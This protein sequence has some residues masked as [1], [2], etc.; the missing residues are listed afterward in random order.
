MSS[1]IVIV[2]SP[3]KAKTIEKFLGKDYT[4]KSSFG[5]VRDLAKKDFGVDIKNNYKPDYEI[6]SDKK[7]IIADLKKS[8]STAQTV[9]LASDEDREGEAI[10][11]HLYEVLNLKK[12]DT[13][14][15]V[16]NEITKSAILNAI[17]N[18][19]TINID[20]VDAQQARRVLDRLV[21]FELSSVLWKK[22]KSQLSAG[23]VQSVS[24]R[25]LV[26]R[27]R[28]I[29]KFVSESAF[30]I[31][32]LFI[33]DNKGVQEILY[34]ELSE[35]FKTKEEVLK[36]MNDCKNANYKVSSVNKKPVK[37]TPAPPF[38]TS[39]LQ[40]EAGRKF[41]FSVSKT[42]QVAQNLYESGFI[43]YMRTDSVNLSNAAKESI[44]DLVVSQYGEKY[45]KLRNF[46][47]K[48]KGAQEAHEAI[49]PSYVE[50]E[51]I[52]G[53]SEQKKLYSLIR[54]RAIASQMSDALLEKT[55]VNIDI[56]TRKEQFIAQGEIV[57]FEGFLKVYQALPDEQSEN[58][59]EKIIPPLK[60]G[61]I[62][63]SD[64]IE[65]IQKFTKHPPRY[66]ESALV[67]KMEELGIGRPSTYAPTISTIQ[68][69]GYVVK[70]NRNGEKRTY[71]YVSLINGEINSQ[72][73]TENYGVEKSKLF[74]TDIGI[75]VNDFLV[76]K[77]PSIVD[78]NFTADVEQQFDQIAAGK[79]VWHKMIDDFYK[80][81]HKIVENTVE[82]AERNSGERILGKDPETGKD[83]SVR[84]GRF[85][86][87][88]QA[89]NTEDAEK[90]R[91]VSIPKDKHLET[92]SLEE[93]LELLKGSG[94]GRK[95]GVDSRTGRNIY[96]RI[97]RFGP[98]VQLGENDDTEKPVFSS[99]KAGMTIENITILQAEE[100]FKLPR[101]VGEYQ[102]KNI[103]AANGKF[104]PYLSFNSS[105][106][107]LKKTDD[108][109]S[110]SLERAIE[111]IEEK[112][113]KD[114][115]KLIKEFPE[116]PSIK[117]INDRWNR[118]CIFYDKKYV[119]ISKIENPKELTLE[120]CKEL[121]GFT[122]KKKTSPS[123]QT[124]AKKA[125]TAKKTSTTKKK[126]E[127]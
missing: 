81:F 7:K 92:I 66:S 96:A 57:V 16:F 106:V 24:V 31:N 118:P 33:V 63:V 49:R 109:L 114:Q 54:N 36:F 46:V 102:G 126:T 105:F 124:T 52:T 27:E 29:I 112:K 87:I 107:S 41:G 59:D 2:E 70:E 104:G 45:H 12:K 61:D 75:V 69:R 76:D 14:R 68:K 19:G 39:T 44:K 79:M 13:K 3:A 103:V 48:S 77:F 37:R 88:V 43:T 98:M 100:L 67:R 42:M 111:L 23:R 22:V 11:W 25:L 26:D 99:L 90:P 78:Y 89:G 94:N 18:P 47:T 71:E 80:P 10:A 51:D 56:S 82:T 97:G 20:L 122:D 85:G 113:Q 62:L 40:Q 74:P 108:P 38:T 83:I 120:K 6:M 84:I 64:K 60:N 15:I 93:A 110:V 21:G 121:V 95:V 1:N 34:S 125:A 123:K 50:N 5:H 73:K 117:I 127:K 55:I 8:V 101:T 9:W 72:K 30:K 58:E 116:E 32:G 17:E 53:T 86:P 119:N 115:E 91:F 35:K 28:E 4:V 65:A